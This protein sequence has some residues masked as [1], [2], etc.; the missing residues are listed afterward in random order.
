MAL[1]VRGGGGCTLA[2][3]AH[4]ALHNLQPA[5]LV[6]YLIVD[7]SGY[8]LMEEQQEATAANGIIEIGPQRGGER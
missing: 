3:K 4:F 8:D 6:R 2:Q 1:L 7:E 5:G